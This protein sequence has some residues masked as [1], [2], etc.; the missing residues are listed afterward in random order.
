M[1]LVYLA[2]NRFQP[3]QMPLKIEL[4]DLPPCYNMAVFVR[5]NG[6]VRVSKTDDG[7]QF[8]CIKDHIDKLSEPWVAHKKLLAL[9]FAVCGKNI[10][11]DVRVPLVQ[12]FNQFPYFCSYCPCQVKVIE[13]LRCLC[14][15]FGCPM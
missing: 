12:R 10:L 3:P 4:A 7:T 15:A 5:D 9:H 14:M 13:A 6:F 2:S 1:P 8:L 11:Y